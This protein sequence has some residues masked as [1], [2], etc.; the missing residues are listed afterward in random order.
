MTDLTA[1]R[2]PV[3]DID[4]L[5]AASGADVR[6]LHRR[7]EPLRR[8]PGGRR[9]ARSRP[10]RPGGSGCARTGGSSAGRSGT[11]PRE[12]GIRQFLDIGSGLPTTSE[13]ARDRAGGRP[14]LAGWSTSTT[15]RWC[16]RTPGRCSPPRRRGAPPTSRPTC[17]S[18][19]DILASPVV[20]SV[21]DF[22]QPVALMLV[23]VLHFLQE[24]DKPEAVL[25]TL[26]DALPPGSVPGRVAR[27]GGARPGRA[28]R[29]AARLPGGGAADADTRTPTSSRSSRSPAW[30]SCRPAWCS[31]RN[32]GRT[33]NAPRPTPAE[34]SC[35]GGVARKP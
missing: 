15:T 29:R 3:P 22:G 9:R 4:T 31:S 6:L 1:D 24:E 33:R 8:R 25:A 18:P 16:S 23:A 11:W 20:R 7:Q 14:V 13:R 27:D 26:L 19:L 10:G 28:R 21:L 5:T 35:Y 17:A 2:L 32:G 12:A 30:S 34:V